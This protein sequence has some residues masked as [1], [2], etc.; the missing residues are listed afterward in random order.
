MPSRTRIVVLSTAAAVIAAAAPAGAQ[1]RVLATEQRPTDVAAWQA[2]AVWSS[3]DPASATYRLVR[4][5][6]GGAPAPL[7]VAPS[8]RPFDP[9]LGTNR[10]GSPYAVYTRCANGHTGCDLYRLGL[11]TGREERLTSLSSGRWDERDPTIFAGRIAFVRR[12]LVG[13]E[14][15]DTIRIGDTT[16]TG[17]PTKVL[18]RGMASHGPS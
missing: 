11:N 4:S 10:S 17:T 14:M 13:G 7:P 3:Y 6:N 9:D 12:E 16:R 18:V 5:Q 2:D 1:E 15:G 8:P